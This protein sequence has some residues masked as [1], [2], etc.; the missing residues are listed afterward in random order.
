MTR[1]WGRWTGRAPR[2]RCPGTGQSL[3]PKVVVCSTFCAPYIQG[4]RPTVCRNGAVRDRE[5]RTAPNATRYKAG[6]AP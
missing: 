2:I 1:R 5:M 3:P 4:C 6:R